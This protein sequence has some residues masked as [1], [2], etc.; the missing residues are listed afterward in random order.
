MPKYN[1]GNVNRAENGELMCLLEESAFAF[2]EST[3]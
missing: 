2:E 1:N 3:E